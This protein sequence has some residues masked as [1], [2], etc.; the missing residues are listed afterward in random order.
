MLVLR[1][2]QPALCRATLRRRDALFLT[3]RAT[4]RGTEEAQERHNN[5]LHEIY[6]HR[7]TARL[8]WQPVLS[9]LDSIGASHAVVGDEEHIRLGGKTVSIAGAG[10]T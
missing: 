6:H 3:V 5:T 8:R 9:L 7:S 2:L 1:S 10:A 4:T